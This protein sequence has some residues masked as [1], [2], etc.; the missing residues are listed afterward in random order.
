MKSLAILLLIL[1]GGA[2]YY[3]YV[4]APRARLTAGTLEYVL[5]VTL[6]VVDT[7]ADVR[8][9]IANLHAGQPVRVISSADS[10]ADLILPDGA[11]GWVPQSD[12][13]D[14]ESFDE[15]QDLLKKA[16]QAPAQASGHIS[17][18]VNVHLKP[19]RNGMTVGQFGLGQHVVVYDRQLTAR[20]PVAGN[21]SASQ[22]TDVWYLVRGGDSAGWVLGDFVSLD[23]PPGLSNYAQGINIVAWM[24]LDTA[25]DNGQQVPQYLAADRVGARRPDFNHIRVFTWWVKRHEYVT[26]YVEGGIDGYF[27][28]TVSHIGGVPYFRLRLVD[29]QGQKF[30]KVYGLFDTIVRPIGVV[31]GWTSDAMP[32]PSTLRGR[33]L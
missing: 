1:V 21:G 15:A 32:A 2:A 4:Y 24:P 14:A 7:T 30:Q 5:P 20:E 31:D 22:R 29:D 17:A 25:D 10:W 11:T 19:S 27:P 16:V 33:R 8:R 6:P 3:H 9:I 28:I 23:I 13:L 12:L 18:P 26:A